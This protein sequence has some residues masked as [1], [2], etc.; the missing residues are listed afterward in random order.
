MLFDWP[1]TWLSA[2]TA[3]AATLVA[4]PLAFAF[5]W[6]ISLDSRAALAG[7]LLRLLPAPVL[8]AAW[9][10][11]SFAWMFAA[12]I[13]VATAALAREAAAL[14][15]ALPSPWFESLRT[16]GAPAWPAAWPSLRSPLLTAA[17]WTAA[18]VFLEALA[19]L[20]VRGASR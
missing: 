14:I 12:G 10:S 11:G 20:L 7:R 15:A 2:Q 6:R 3:I 8:L 4:F 5:G 16:L 18:R 1:S 17:A 19:G 13:L 9:W